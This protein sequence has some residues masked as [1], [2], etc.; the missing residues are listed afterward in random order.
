MTWLILSGLALMGAISAGTAVTIE[1]FKENAIETGKRELE[2]AVLLLARHFDR[3]FDDFAVVQKQVMEELHSR[4]IASPDVFRG[5]MGT[6]AVHKILMAKANGWADF[7]GVHV[8]DFKG[9]LINSSQSWPVPDISIDDRD[10]FRKLREDPARSLEIGVV[11]TSHFFAASAIVFARRVSGPHG[12]F[13]GVVTRALTPE[14]LETFFASAGLGPEASI[15]L[16]HRDG[17]LLARYPHVQALIGQNF[18]AGSSAQRAVFLQTDFAGRLASPMDGKDRLVASRMLTTYPLVIVATNTLESALAGWRS[19]TKFFIALAGSAILVIALTLYLVFRQIARELLLEKLRLDTAVNNMGQGLLLFDASERLIVCNRKYLDMYGLSAE[20]IKPGCS[21]RDVLR[22]REA[23]G[24]FSGDVEGYCDE[25]LQNVHTANVSVIETSD[26]RLIQIGN[27]PVPGG[28]WVATHEDVTERVRSQETIVHLA[29]YDALTDLPNRILFRAHIE[30]KLAGSEA[31]KRFAILYIDV[32]EFKSVNDTLGH[33]VGDELLKSI[34]SRLQACVGPGDLVARLGGDEF[35]VVKAE[36]GEIAEIAALAEAVHAAIRSPS[37]CLGQ[38]L[39]MDAS[40]GIALAPE[41]GT[42]LEELLKRA[43]LAMY[44]AKAGG[45]R[46]YRFF[47]PEMDV[48]MKNRLKLEADLRHAMRD[49]GLEIHYQ[50]LVDLGTNKVTGCEALLR[51]RHSERGMIPPAEFIP[52]AEEAGLINQ[53]GEWVLRRACA[54]AVSWPVEI[55]L[56][57]NVSPVQFKSDTL[58]LKVV[59]AL[60]ESGLSADRLELEITE[61]VLIR[62]DEEALAILTQLRGLGVRIALDDFGT[63]YS[64]LSYLR[65]FP[66]DKIKIDRSF[67]SDLAE[68]DGSSTIVQAVVAMASARRMTTTA[69]GVETE[70]QREI[71]CRLG[72]GQ[73][74]G[75]L[76][77]PAVPAA[78]LQD[79]LSCRSPAAGSYSTPVAADASRRF[80][81]R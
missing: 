36:F 54:D 69:E 46:T 3:Q 67:V 35:A 45:R 56:A 79:L 2:G 76:F 78:R 7:A 55:R 5:E 63:G 23:T 51:W 71:L 33:L 13:L 53:L 64:S 10:Y 20:V 17:V 74:Q 4:A 11:P 62:D 32:D 68:V 19:E 48:R 81:S 58:A 65:R 18:K 66:F 49:G 70:E 39:S 29:H 77:S 40:I 61:A 52:V 59:S 24:S 43:D 8:Y 57:V 6:L 28:G 41:H 30:R 73:M 75:Y 12:E 31:G 42:N 21:F 9:T 1:R 15:S 27:E 25:I 72:C 22:H 38:E 47:A 37:D 26:G 14:S 16:H 80:G 44:A 50:P 34:A 60:A